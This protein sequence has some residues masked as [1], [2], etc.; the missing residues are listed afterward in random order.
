MDEKIKVLV[1]GATGFIGRHLVEEL[2]KSGEYNILCTTRKLPRA[3][4]LKKFGVKIIQADIT[5]KYSLEKVFNQK[6]DIVFH[7]AGYVANSN[8]ELLYKINALGT[9]NICDLSLKSGVKRVVYTSSVAV[10]SGNTEVPLTED[11]PFKATNIYGESKIEA[12]RK[13]LEYRKKGLK[14]VIVRPPIVYGE[15]EPHMMRFMLFLLKYRLLPLIDNGQNKFHLAYVKNVVK[16]MVYSL[17]NEGFLEGT[18]FIADKEV[19]SSKEV[20][21]AMCKGIRAKP[22]LN[23]P[24]CLKAVLM[25]LPYVGKKLNFFTRDMIYST[26][27]IEKLGFNFPY[28]G[29][30]S[31]PKSAEE[32]FYGKN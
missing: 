32:L 13:A 4:F 5:E 23:I 20:F 19:L 31:I 27:R 11:L 29:E 28:S 3:T 1:I 12:E 18:F 7:C 25:P 22:P 30:D 16:L 17:G 15:D 2:S 6:I 14:I 21:T 8:S 24:N 26:K 10:V 9:E